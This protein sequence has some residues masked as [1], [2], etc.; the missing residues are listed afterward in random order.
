MRGSRARVWRRTRVREI[1]LVPELPTDRRTKTNVIAEQQIFPSIGAVQGNGQNRLPLRSGAVTGKFKLL[2]ALP[3]EQSDAATRN[4]AALNA[5]RTQGGLLMTLTKLRTIALAGTVLLGTAAMGYAQSSSTIGAGG[6]TAGGGAGSGAAS[7]LGVGG[8][9]AG[10]GSASTSLGTG[11]SAAGSGK[12][13]SGS[14][15]TIGA[16]GSTA[17]KGSASSSMGTGGSSAGT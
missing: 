12:S 5:S 14:A 1:V 6:S 16:G 7:T 17:G 11:G 4:A 8:A 3:I 10:N 13:G 2:A 15:S 9:T